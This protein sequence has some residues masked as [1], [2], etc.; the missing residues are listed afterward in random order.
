[1]YDKKISAELFVNTHYESTQFTSVL[2]VVPKKKNAEFYGIY[3]ELLL[4][5][6][7]NDL[8]NWEKRNRSQ[9]T[10]A[11]QNVEDEEAAKEIIEAEISASVKAHND[12]IKMPGVIPQS[13]KSLGE[14]DEEGNELFR[15]ITL[16]NQTVDFV[17]L[18]KKNGFQAARFDYNVKLYMENLKL[19]QKL[20][21]DLN[22]SQ[23]QVMNT[24]KHNFQELF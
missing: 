1:M 16:T 19:E 14:T 7:Q 6:N 5:F 8:A 24:C 3:E 18:L 9:I 22:T 23:I 11:H 17:R 2:V 13:A 12:A 4:K 21:L 15:I 20:K 10:M